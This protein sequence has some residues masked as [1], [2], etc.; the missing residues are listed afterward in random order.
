MA[1][2]KRIKLL[3]NENVDSLGIVGDVVEV[4]AGFA[5]N[6]L[7]PHALATTPTPSN[8]KRLEARRAEVQ[9]QLAALRAEQQATF[10]KLENKEVTLMRS[11]NEQGQLFGS[12]TQHDIVAALKE[13]GIHIT[14]R[15]VRIGAPIK[16]LDIYKI[17]IQFDKELKTEIKLYVVSDK[18]QDQLQTETAFAEPTEAAEEATEEP[19]PKKGKKAK[20]EAEAAAAE[21]EP[22]A[23]PEKKGKKSKGEKAEK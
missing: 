16:H 15:D 3:L 4:R 17:P 19:K 20:A 9:A 8:V 1:S 22:E 7:L 5:R 21:P 11:A 14:E 23:K 10:A 6:Y 13:E 2:T 18:P 12:V